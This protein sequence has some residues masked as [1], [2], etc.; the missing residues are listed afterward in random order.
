MGY[1]D[2]MGGMACAYERLG[3]GSATK[4]ETNQTKPN[5]N[6]N[7]NELTVKQTTEDVLEAA[8]HAADC[9]VVRGCNGVAVC[10]RDY[11]DIAVRQV[12]TR[13]DPGVF[14][15]VSWWLAQPDLRASAV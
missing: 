3:H 10:W 4:D 8:A 2:L 14:R 5:T 9:Y 11:D 12:R 1:D 7:T 6:M 15:P 13:P